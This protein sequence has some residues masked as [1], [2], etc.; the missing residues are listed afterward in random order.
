M[1]VQRLDSL[2]S[3]LRAGGFDALLVNSLPDIRYLTGF[4]GSNALLVITP[5]RAVLATDGR[6]TVQS[7]TEVKG[8]DTLIVAGSLFD[9]LIRAVLRRAVLRV[10]VQK[11]SLTVAAFG[12]MRTHRPRWSWRSA[13]DIVSKTRHTKDSS[14]IE[15]IRKAVGISDRVFGSI[16]RIL[17]PGVRE[18]EVAAEISYLH[19]T[20]GADADAFEPIVAS[21]VRGA[22]PHAR[23][24]DKKIRAGELVTL[25]FGCRVGGYHS[26]ITR[27]V[28]VGRVSRTLKR[29]HEAVLSAQRAALATIR[30]EIPARDPDAIART[31]LRRYRLEKRFTHS[32]GHG[33]GLEVH[34]A[35]RL[36][37][38]SR[39]MLKAGMVVTVEPGV[40]VPGVGGVRIE[41]DVVVHQSGAEVL[42]T[43]QKELVEV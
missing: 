39:E 15:L 26:D 13:D 22:L 1:H 41:D 32:L 37:A 2:R 24:S 18:S 34:E 42:S 7:R 28:A 38:T 43:A 5:R 27:T 40:Y 19:R 10:G 14:E 16:L 23:A 3:S 11:E 36:A 8:A 29:M 6:Y 30:A 12:R 21:G 9:G 17:A 20:L 31:I 35:P 33:L 4:T 25:D